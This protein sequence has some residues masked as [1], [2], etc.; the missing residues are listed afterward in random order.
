MRDMHLFTMKD[1]VTIYHLACKEVEETVDEWIAANN[2]S[3]F[4]KT[5]YRERKREFYIGI[6]TFVACYEA[7]TYGFYNELEAMQFRLTFGDDFDYEVID[8]DRASTNED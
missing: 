1:Y 6:G 5:E 2:V 7:A 8:E 3:D 4:L